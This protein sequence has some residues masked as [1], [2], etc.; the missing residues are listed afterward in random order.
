VRTGC[1]PEL[2]TDG[3]GDVSVDGRWL[4]VNGARNAALLVDLDALGSGGPARPAG[5]AL[6]GA[7]TWTRSGAALHVDATGAL[8]RVRPDELA[9]GEQPFSSPVDGIAPGDRP[10]V[11]ADTRP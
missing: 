4:L 2:A 10:V 5:P 1:G 3:L 7:V 8:V 9:A 6:T 11:V